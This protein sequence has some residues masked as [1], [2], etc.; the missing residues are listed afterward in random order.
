MLH[1]ASPPRSLE[2]KEFTVTLLK[3][4]DKG[5]GFLVQC[6]TTKPHVIVSE[7]NKG[8]SQ[9]EHKVS[10]KQKKLSIKLICI[11]YK[12]LFSSRHLEESFT[13]SIIVHLSNK[14]LIAVY[15]IES[16]VSTLSY[17]ATQFKTYVI[18]KA[19]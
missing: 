11:F 6:R 1:S 3:S 5:L 13:D 17:F 18:P 15:V 2:A 19:R 9:C 7:I 14:D 10:L 4:K 12:Y 16:K 8:K